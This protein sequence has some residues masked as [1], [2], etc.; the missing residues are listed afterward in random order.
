MEENNRGNKLHTDREVYIDFLRIMAIFF[1][2]F[3]HTGNKGFTYFTIAQNSVLFPF[4]MFCA[5]LCTIAVPVFFMI[6]GA[7]LLRKDESISVVLKKRFLKYLIV[8]CCASLV[9]YI[10]KN[11]PGEISTKVFFRTLY[12]SRHATAL[13]YLYTY[14]GFILTLPMLRKLSRLMK[15]SDYMYM[16]GIMFLFSLLKV[17]D[18]FIFHNEARYNGDFSVV[19]TQS[20]IYYPLIGDF[21]ANKIS[22][23]NINKK[24]LAFCLIL[25][26]S[27]VIL[28]CYLTFEWCSYIG[29]F[30][31]ESCQKFINTFVYLTASAVFLG[32]RYLFEKVHLKEKWKKVIT[33]LGSCTFGVYLFETLFRNNTKFIFTAIDLYLPT[34]AACFIW[35]TSALVLGILVTSVLKKI[36]LLRRLVS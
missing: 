10:A 16:T 24:Q 2:I 8:L 13:W 3:N 23:K 21:L 18:F 7:L 26:F 34:Y 31:E 1:V 30:K 20:A 27:A 6:S 22:L 11:V 12:T 14:L 5:S 9:I 4:Y 36:P 32:S 25:G 29:E 33:Y 17:F 35:V 19:F 28:S 15:P